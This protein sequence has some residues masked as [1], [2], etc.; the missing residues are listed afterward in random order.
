MQVNQG[1]YSQAIVEWSKNIQSK[2][3]A[4]FIVFDIES[5]YLSKFF[6]LFHKAINFVKTIRDVSEK[7]ISIIMQSIG[8]NGIQIHDLVL[9]M[10]TL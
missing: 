2:S 6:E 7:D 10:K 3:N 1:K 8:S 5:F 9:T 4:S